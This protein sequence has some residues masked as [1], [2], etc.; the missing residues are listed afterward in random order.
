MT[1][2]VNFIKNPAGMATVAA[3]IIWAVSTAYAGGIG[4]GARLSTALAFSTFVVIVIS[5][6]DISSR[7]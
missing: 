3:I 6:G 2:F 4:A 1:R 5:A 7:G